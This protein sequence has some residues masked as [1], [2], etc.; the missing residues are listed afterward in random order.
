VGV[1]VTA[2]G[3]DAPY[4]SHASLGLKAPRTHEV[5]PGPLG[6][7]VLCGPADGG[8]QDFPVCGWAGDGIV[9]LVA[10]IGDNNPKYVEGLILTVR[11]GVTAAITPA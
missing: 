7:M 9:G 11:A 10:Y 8:G 2:A 5:A 6:G 1:S 3:I 4:Q